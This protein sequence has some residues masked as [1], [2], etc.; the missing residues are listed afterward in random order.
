MMDKADSNIY[1]FHCEVVEVISTG[2]ESTIKVICN[3]G[4]IIIE[5]P[6]E[7]K[8]KMGDRIIVTGNLNILSS[9]KDCSSDPY[10]IPNN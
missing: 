3:P 1:R 5:I 2:A 6:N 8:I 9:E 4:S 10:N 7:R